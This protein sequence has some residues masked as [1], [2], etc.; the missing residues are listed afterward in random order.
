[1]T[2]PGVYIFILF[3]FFLNQLFAQ[4]N[5]SLLYLLE[6]SKND[7][8]IIDASLEMTSQM[9]RKSPVEALDYAQ[10][11]VN[12][13]Q[14]IS[15][16][17]R[18]FDALIIQGVLFKNLGIYEDA[19]DNYLKA[20]D[21]ANAQKDELKKSVCYNNIGSVYQAQGNLD[22][23][24]NYYK[25]S[26]EIEELL[27][28]KARISLRYYNVGTVYE[29]KD[30]LDL[31]Y[32]YY[33]NSLL[34]EQNLQNKEGIYFALYGLAG[35]DIKRGNLEQAEQFLNKALALAEEIQDYAGM[36]MC[37]IERGKLNKEKADFEQSIKD[38]LLSI[39][40]A[41]KAD[42]KLEIREAYFQL[43]EIYAK[44]EQ[45]KSAFDFQ[46]KYI[47]LH[48]SLSSVEVNTKIA[49][50]ETRYKIAEKEKEISFL[51]E[52]DEILQKQAK[53]EKRN[54]Y[55][56]L[57]TLFITMIFALS[58][59][60]RIT[61][62]VSV[63]L[64]ISVLTFL[65][66]LVVTFV[67]T[68]ITSSGS[69]PLIN[70]FFSTLLSVLSIAILPVFMAILIM[71]RW[72]FSRHVKIAQDVSRKIQLADK[73]SS[74]DKIISLIAENDKDKLEIH[75]SSLL[76]IEASDNYSAIYYRQDKQIHKSLLRSSLKRMEEQLQEFDFIVRC[77]KSYIVNLSQITKVSGNAQGYKL[78]ISDVQFE[79]PVS[80]K[81]P[82][83]YLEQKK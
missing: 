34:T 23:A 39:R 32:T 72:M 38:L 53:S 54:R 83:S 57:A 56:L 16:V 48:D 50:I 15:D 63:L 64:L 71:E 27:G 77:H 5:D 49:E 31:A 28:D 29:L 19:V 7:T 40:Y 1:M 78:H 75:I 68:L 4:N 20:L 79:I 46:R 82:K 17:N 24:L 70:D 45:Y 13:S 58:N 81:F 66:L 47:V 6:H 60:N 80:R 12:L 22:N 26:L 61:K 65:F 69:N 30:S 59:L 35:V 74:D 41:E 8:V 67:F 14:K 44:M 62:R 33:Y 73:K 76:Y 52:K 43:S 2:K 37:L 9:L 25:Q 36:A 11:A 3:L 21:I 42:F 51:L 55:Y 10:S 18:E